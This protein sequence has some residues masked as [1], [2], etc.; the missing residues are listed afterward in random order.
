MHSALHTHTKL[1]AR[2]GIVIIILKANHPHQNHS[3][4]QHC[5][6]QPHHHDENHHNEPEQAML[7]FL[8]IE[9]RSN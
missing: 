3:H 8:C 7:Q 4:L 9:L 1:Q 5:I 2:C 6:A